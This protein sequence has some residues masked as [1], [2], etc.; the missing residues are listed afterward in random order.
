[1][2]FRHGEYE[3]DDGRERF[4]GE[5]VYGWLSATYWSLNVSPGLL[6]RALN[7]SSLVVG[8]YRDRE[9]VGCLRVVSDRATFA[10][11][12][13]VFVTEPHRGK[14]LA[15]AMV[16]FALNH[17]DHQG[18]RRWMLATRDAHAVY[19][20]VG[21]TPLPDPAQIMIYRPRSSS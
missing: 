3:I 11:I 21:F 8:A 20:G 14:G 6:R 4:D 9:Q 2:I 7:G 12:A 15:R 1:M 19:G 13:D 10:W 16:R 5:C 18:L 17:P